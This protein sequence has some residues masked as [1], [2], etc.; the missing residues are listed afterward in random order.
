MGAHK[1]ENNI[2]GGDALVEEFC[3]DAGF[4]TVLFNPNFVISNTGMDHDRMNP[5]AVAPAAIDE[6][7]VIAEGVADGEGLDLVMAG[8]MLAMFLND[9]FEGLA[10]GCEFFHRVGVVGWAMG[11][12]K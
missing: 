2:L 8:L 9:V 11:T 5:A 1:A 6:E 3:C 4:C 12:G 7:I 10:I